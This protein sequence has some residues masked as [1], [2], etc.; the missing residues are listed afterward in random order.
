MTGILFLNVDNW[1]ME[2]MMHVWNASGKQMPSVCLF[3]K[4]CSSDFM[5]SK[6]ADRSLRRTYFFYHR[7]VNLCVLAA[8][9]HKCRSNVLVVSGRIAKGEMSSLWIVVQWNQGGCSFVFCKP[10]ERIFFSFWC[11]IES[12]LVVPTSL[13]QSCTFW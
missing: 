13:C 12:S 4:S 6:G 1:T 9:T 5:A 3:V 7:N 8:G 11:S 2:C 10:N